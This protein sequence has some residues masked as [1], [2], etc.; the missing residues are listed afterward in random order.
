MD[1]RL[2]KAMNEQLTKELYSAYLYLSM[3]AYLQSQKLA[4]FSHWMKMQAQEE[5]LHAMRFFDFLNEQG[6]RVILEA[7]DKPPTEFLSAEDVFE[8]TL[9]HEQ[10]VSGYI[11]DLQALAKEV[12]DQPACVLLEWFVKEQIE[13]ERTP[14][15]ILKK[16]KEASSQ[17]DGVSI[18]DEKLSARPQP[19]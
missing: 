1:K 7:I 18:L 5:C 17:S 19:S 15:N 12:N 8:K 11:K 3:A 2:E 14:A 10:K 13:E 9:R 6:C 16:I 4:G